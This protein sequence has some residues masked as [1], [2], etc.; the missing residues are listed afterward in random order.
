MHRLAQAMLRDRNLAD[1]ACQEVWLAAHRQ[2]PGW[3]PPRAWLA[4]AV[5]RV[6]RGLRR[7]AARRAGRDRCPAAPTEHPSTAEVVARTEMHQRLIRHVLE[8]D[9]PLRT[10]TLLHFQ[11]GRS[12]ADI[13][14]LE[15]CP[16][17]T[18]RWRLRRAIALLR[19]ACRRELGEDWRSPFAAALPLPLRLSLGDDASAAAPTAWLWSL[20]IMSKKTFVAL[21]GGLLAL[22]VAA[23]WPSDA[24][25]PPALQGGGHVPVAATGAIDRTATTGTAPDPD[26]APAPAERSRIGDA[27]ALGD[28]ETLLQGRVVDGADRPLPGAAIAVSL[29]EYGK[30]DAREVWRRSGTADADGRFALRVPA[31]PTETIQIQVTDGDFRTREWFRCGPG[32][33]PPHHALTPGRRDLGTMVL[34]EAG[35]IWGR[36]VGPRGEP[37]PSALVM[38]P[39]AVEWT[40]TEGSYRMPHVPPG[41]HE[42]TVHAQ[43][44][45]EA[46][47]E[48]DVAAGHASERHIALTAGAPVRGWIV[49]EHG[50]GVAGVA[51]RPDSG[52]CFHA[53]TKSDA[54]GAFRVGLASDAPACLVVDDE[55]YEQ[56]DVIDVEFAP[57][58]EGVRITVR[59]VGDETE[60][61]FVDDATG[62]PVRRFRLTISRQAG[63]R[64]AHAPRSEVVLLPER[65]APAGTVRA[66]VRPGLDRFEVEAPGYARTAGE[67]RHDDD[68]AA[69]RQTVRLR[70]APH[71]VGRVLRAGAPVAGAKVF[72]T[73]CQFRTLHTTDATDWS[74]SDFGG[75]RPDWRTHHR[76][77]ALLGAAPEWDCIPDGPALT[78]TTTDAD[79]RFRLPSNTGKPCHLRID[80]ADSPSLFRGPLDGRRSVDLGDLA[81]PRSVRVRGRIELALP[82]EIEGHPIEVTGAAETRV[83]TDAA[84]CFEFESGPGGCLLHLHAER[85]LLLWSARG[86]GPPSFYVDV[87]DRPEVSCVLSIPNQPAAHFDF[88]LRAPMPPDDCLVELVPTDGADPFLVLGEVDDEGRCTG[89]AP[90][91]GPCW[92]DIVSAG[93]RLRAP[94]GAWDVVAGTR[95]EAPVV[96]E[97]GEL[98]LP[99]P[100]L[101]GLARIAIETRRADGL[102]NA[103][104][105]AFRGGSLAGSVPYAE[106]HGTDLLLQLLPVGDTEVHVDLFAADGSVLE[107]RR[108]SARIEA[109]TVT[110]SR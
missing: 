47:V 57:G 58:T 43:H 106:L 98:S 19:A 11:D 40:G 102:R 20:T 32:Q 103:F 107:R 27:E 36:V 99:L 15:R 10:T 93:R 54:D 76:V 72:L 44:H 21:S 22:V 29:R 6:S 7:G 56:L 80:H 31:T 17:D 104:E 13:A 5:R 8:L 39:E 55:R 9:E 60:F 78:T 97:T 50:R 38:G 71:I 86:E 51:L 109:G 28:D 65:S 64:G 46:V 53:T 66:R 69:P 74:R 67:V 35:V 96:V 24:A 77:V 59:E 110:T 89:L 16:A 62:A 100:S 68:D 95:F 42:L 25:T 34:H 49:D 81:L 4:E 90:A 91:L 3:Q 87:P 88:V 1:D 63:R 94:G 70:P 26:P 82:G 41:R 83:R 85:G 14:V 73:A 105:F 30:H 18:I 92:C 48:V 2:R 23:A 84:G 61:R 101:P 52:Y 33:E 108:T 75:F 79:G 12:V 45:R 37:L